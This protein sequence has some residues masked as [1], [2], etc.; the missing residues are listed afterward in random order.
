[1]IWLTLLAAVNY[2][3]WFSL[4]NALYAMHLAALVRLWAI[5]AVR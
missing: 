4:E 1:M 2:R 3:V 5:P